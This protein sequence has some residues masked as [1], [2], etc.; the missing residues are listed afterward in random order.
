MRIRQLVLVA[1]QLEPVQQQICRLFGLEVAYHDP[2]VVRYGLKNAVIPVGESFL[3]VIA[4]DREGTTAGRF[5][6]RRDGDGGY[7]VILQCDDIE[8]ERRH[9]ESLGIRV[10][11]KIDLDDAWGTHLHPKDVP[12]AILSVDAMDP[13]ESWRWAGPEWRS[14]ARTEVATKLLGATLQSPNPDALARRWSDVLHEPLV[15]EGDVPAIRL[16][17]TTV[18]FVPPMDSRGEGLAGIDIAVREPIALVARARDMKLPATED[19]VDVGGV[20]FRL[21]RNSE[22][23]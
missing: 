6:E 13:P 16:E 18:R 7:M 22:V 8:A 12:G 15:Q 4:P 21:V 9:I 20:R 14:H 1:R 23:R 10:V 5:L 3:E 17:E 2:G 19:S 11:E